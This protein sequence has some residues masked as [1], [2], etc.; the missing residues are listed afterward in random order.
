M[1]MGMLMVGASIGA[2]IVMPFSLSPENG[3]NFFDAIWLAMGLTVLAFLAVT[4][5]LV[6]PEK[7]AH[8][9]CAAPRHPGATPVLPR[10]CPA[11]PPRYPTLS[12]TRAHH[13]H[14]YICA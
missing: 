11:L 5:V 1:V 2:F 7:R 14:A 6:P 13:A 3:E 10:R 8:A 4:F 12:M 9:P